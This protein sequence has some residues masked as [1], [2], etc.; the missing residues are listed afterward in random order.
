MIIHEVWN[1]HILIIETNYD[2]GETHLYHDERSDV[3]FERK[4]RYA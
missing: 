3:H 1:L 4:K 2:A